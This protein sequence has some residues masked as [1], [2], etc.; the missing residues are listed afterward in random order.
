MTKTR[1][2]ADLGGGFIQSGTG[3]VQR[4]VE[5]KL[6]DMVSVKDFGAVGD[7]VTDDTA[8][9]QAAIDSRA[10]INAGGAV[11]FPNGNY[12]VSSTINLTATGTLLIGETKSMARLYPNHTNGPVLRI[13]RGSC[14]VKDLQIISVGDRLNAPTDNIN[15]GIRVESE[16]E[17]D[18]PALRTKDTHFS[19]LT[20]RSQPSHGIVIIGPAFTGTLDRV[21]MSACGGHGIVFD[22]G[23]I[24][25]R[26]NLIDGP[27]SGICNLNNCA[28]F[29]MGGHSVCIGNPADNYATQALRVV[30]NNIESGNCATDAS[31]RYQDANVYIQGHHNEIRTCVFNQSAL[32]AGIFVAGRNNYIYNNRFIDCT[33]SVVVDSHTSLSTNN[34]FIRGIGTLGINQNPTVLVQSTLGGIEPFGVI[35]DDYYPGNSPLLLTGTGMDPGSGVNR[36]PGSTV[37]SSS[38]GVVMKATDTIV[39]N[40]ITY[41]QDNELYFYTKGGKK[42]L[43]EIGLM[44]SSATTTPNVR[45]RLNGLELNGL[46][47]SPYG[48]VI[49]DTT[50]SLAVRVISADLTPPDRY[51]LGASPERRM[52]SFIGTVSPVNDGY[53]AVEIAQVTATAEDTKLLAGFS[54]LK[55]QEVA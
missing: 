4:T 23:L 12:V 10:V 6:Q 55:W 39:N 14:Q 49:V 42:Y 48:G 9:I 27:I 19:D 3:A 32:N 53:V 13:T 34:I 36:V 37:N 22:R 52:H 26:T 2:L 1:D 30:V 17:P 28:I 51:N 40:S 5:S 25:G 15:C 46:L 16:D 18:S 8:A 43:F 20:I 41:V 33:H 29:N 54:Y 24:T 38:N 11:Y 31:V 21:F 47:Y 44:V 35:V 7:G 50:A 45:F